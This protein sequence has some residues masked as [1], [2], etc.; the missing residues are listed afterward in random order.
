M[1]LTS[2]SICVPLPSSDITS[3]SEPG[4]CH[5][6]TTLES[7]PVIIE[8]FCDTVHGS[9]PWNRSHGPAIA[10]L[11]IGLV[12]EI[13]V[14]T[15]IR[16]QKGTVVITIVAI[17]VPVIVPQHH[18]LPSLHL[19]HRFTLTLSA[20]VSLHPTVHRLHHQTHQLLAV[21]S[22]ITMVTCIGNAR[23]PRKFQTP[24]SHL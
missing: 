18:M 4:F 24:G 13:I 16:V 1:T 12:H 5:Y 22:V 10:V 23:A 8:I 3:E 15:L 21:S 14:L 2:L 19:Q 11:T 17:N 9:G 6:T 7:P 20:T